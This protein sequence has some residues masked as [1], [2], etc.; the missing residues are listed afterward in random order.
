MVTT[1]CQSIQQSVEVIRNDDCQH[2]VFIPNVF[3]PNG[4]QVNDEFTIS[5]S[6]TQD[7][8]TVS[9]SIFDRWGNLV[10]NSKEINFSWDGRF[11]NEIVQSGVYA[12][13]INVEYLDGENRMFKGDVTIIH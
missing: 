13:L 12:Y 5:F 4:D 9:S 2:D 8:A 10:Y 7:I 11:K 6:S 3:S 1:A